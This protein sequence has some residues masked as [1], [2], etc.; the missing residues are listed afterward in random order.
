MVDLSKAPYLDRFNPE[1]QWNRVNFLG[2]RGL[3]ASELNE[4]QSILHYYID[5]LGSNIMSNGDILKGMEGSMDDDGN[6]VVAPG[7]I[8]IEGK[9][10]DFLG[11]QIPAEDYLE[12]M[13]VFV[14]VR[15]KIITEEEDESLLDQNTAL[16]N[17]FSP[18]AHRMKEEVYLTLNEHE[19]T[20]TLYEPERWVRTKT[21]TS[22]GEPK[23]MTAGDQWHR[24][25]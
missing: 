19:G 10:R 2:D 18:G 21:V 3:Q 24:E 17:Y 14:G 9:I 20:A 15:Q 11:G 22:A 16:A 1:N 23:G 4:M 25:Y 5:K 12:G 7:E 6:F 13:K 8:F